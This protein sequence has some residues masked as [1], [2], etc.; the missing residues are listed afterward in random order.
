MLLPLLLR[1]W[2]WQQALYLPSIKT[3]STVSARRRSIALPC[4]KASASKAM[5]IAGATVQHRH[6]M[7][8]DPLRPNL[9]QV[10]LLQTELLDDVNDQGFQVFPGNL[11]ENI[12][13][14]GIDLPGLPAG[15]RLR[16]GTDAIV[17]VTGLRTP[18]VYIERFRPGLLVLM[19]KALPDGS[20]A[21]RAGVM[22]I[23]RCGG[24]IYPNDAIAVQLPDGE[25]RAL[26]PV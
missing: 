16:I 19:N 12:S 8:K 2:P 6:D 4:W 15:T 10:H 7:K 25:H 20:V 11:G 1:P 13:T 24:V 23:V 5:R 22:G 14:R 17:E 21:S 9:R 3:Q 26:Q 18:C